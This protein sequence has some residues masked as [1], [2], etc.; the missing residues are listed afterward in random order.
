MELHGFTL[1]CSPRYGLRATASPRCCTNSSRP[2]DSHVVGDLAS[3]DGIFTLV[4]ELYVKLYTS[5]RQARITYQ[6]KVVYLYVKHVYIM[7]PYTY[8]HKISH[9]SLHGA[10]PGPGPGPWAAAGTQARSGPG[11]GPGPAHARCV[12]FLCIC[13]DVCIFVHIHVYQVY[14]A[15][16]LQ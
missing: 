15:N 12:Y 16:G 10:G 8:V 2:P 7:Y 9:I 13:I 6:R 5:T 4:V 3:G 1:I 11:P 14:R